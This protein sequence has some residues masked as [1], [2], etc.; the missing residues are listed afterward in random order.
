M[1]AAEEGR[2]QGEI[3]SRRRGRETD[4]EEARQRDAAEALLVLQAGGRGRRYGRPPGRIRLRRRRQARRLGKAQGDEHATTRC[5]TTSSRWKSSTA[6]D[7]GATA[8]RPN[9]GASHEAPRPHHLIVFTCS[10]GRAALSAG[11]PVS[12]PPWPR[13][14]CRRRPSPCARCF[15][16]AF[17]AADT[18]RPGRRALHVVCVKR[19]ASTA[20]VRRDPRTPFRAC[21]TFRRPS[22]ASPSPWSGRHPVPRPLS[23]PPPAASSARSSPLQDEIV[24]HL[25]PFPLCLDERPEAGEPDLMRR[26][27]HRLRQVPPPVVSPRPSLRLGF[28]EHHRSPRLV[29]FGPLGQS[30]F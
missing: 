26:I 17:T 5:R 2:S 20:P 30:L 8:S 1:A 6:I 14:A 7:A 24:E 22:S 16:S 11:T 29:A 27:E 4:Q 23:R 13:A 21:P 25:H 19:R 12:R 9:G 18:R 3:R 15:R 28:L 10:C